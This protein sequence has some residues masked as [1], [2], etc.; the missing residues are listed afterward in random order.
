MVSA[1]SEPQLVGSAG[2]IAGEQSSLASTRPG[3]WPFWL[4]VWVLMVGLLVAGALAWASDALYTRDENRLLDVRVREAPPALRLSSL[5]P[6]T[7][8]P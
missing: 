8:R 4:A 5:A 1:H 7:P 2:R 3:R 6:R